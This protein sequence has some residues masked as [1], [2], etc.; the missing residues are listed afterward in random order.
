MS[1]FEQIMMAFKKQKLSFTDNNIF[2]G[3]VERYNQRNSL[4]PKQALWFLKKL[5]KSQLEVPVEY[6][7]YIEKPTLPEQKHA[8]AECLQMIAKLSPAYHDEQQQVERF[9]SM[10]KPTQPEVELNQPAAVTP[11]QRVDTIRLKAIKRS[12]E[13]ALMHIDGML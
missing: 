4:T 13:D 1:E 12:L 7:D 11:Q 3:I 6:A 5:I 9:E 10:F 8:H 2:D